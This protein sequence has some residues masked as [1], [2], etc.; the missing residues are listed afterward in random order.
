M[1]TASQIAL[2]IVGGGALG[3]G[4]AAATDA[5][6]ACRD[7][8]ARGDAAAAAAACMQRG[9]GLFVF[10]GH[11]FGGTRLAAMARVVRGGFGRSGLHFGFGS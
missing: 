4:I 1:R 6:A 5:G 11:N 8:R 10:A 3:F 2:L 7:A 9:G